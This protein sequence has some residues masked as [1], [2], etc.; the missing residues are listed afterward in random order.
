[1]PKNDE[2]SYWQLISQSMEL[3][4]RRLGMF[5]RHKSSLGVGRE[6]I[7]RKFLI[8]VTP[9]PYR[10][11]TGFVV[12]PPNPSITSDQCDILVYDPRESQPLYNIEQFVVLPPRATRLAIEVR[13]NMSING[14]KSGIDH[15]FKVQKS[16]LP[17]A[18]YTHGFGFRG[19]VFDTFVSGLVDRVDGDI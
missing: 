10:V 15:V 3:E 5:V 16:L 17:F 14:K 4:D 12:H 1:M 18:V 7:L 11:S 6:N 9:E 8:G 13:S 19:P 2:I